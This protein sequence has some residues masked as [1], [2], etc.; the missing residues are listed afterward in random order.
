MGSIEISRQI[1]IYTYLCKIQ[2]APHTKHSIL[3]LGKASKV[4]KVSFI[5]TTHRVLKYIVW[6]VFDLAGRAV[7]S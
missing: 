3:P 5:Q 6:E 7:F 1:N 2:S 4:N